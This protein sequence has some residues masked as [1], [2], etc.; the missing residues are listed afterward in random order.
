MRRRD[1]EARRTASG[2]AP[3]FSPRLCAFA[4]CLATALPA[5][6]QTAVTREGDWWV[7]SFTGSGTLPPGGRLR[8]Q[9]RGDVDA[10]G[11][12]EGQVS[13]V[14][15]ARVKADN[16]ADAR[17][18]LGAFGVKFFKGDSGPAALVLQPGWGNASLK[19][20]APRTLRELVVATGEGHVQASGLGGHVTLASNAGDLKA[21]RLEGSLTARSGGGSIVLGEIRGAVHAST[22]GGDISARIIRGDAVLETGGGEVAVQE[23]G[24]TVRASTLGGAVRIS[25]AGAG[26]IAST[27]GGQIDVGEARGLVE[28]RNSGG[29]LHVGAAQGVRCETAAGGIKLSNVSG[30]L[31]CST[32]IGS[33]VAR[34]IRGGQ[35]G[36]SFLSTGR[37][38]IT[39]FIPSNLGVKIHAENELAGASRRIVSDFPGISTRRQGAL[40]IAEG[41]VNGGGPLLRISGTGG[42]I[43]IKRQ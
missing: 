21:D 40:A 31:R 41:D 38:D 14:I 9:A 27:G 26:V 34:L 2:G 28:L 37:G 18:R 24:G 33:I 39:V 5:A 7:G 17:K 32:A 42:T 22:A 3:G 10:T 20:T 13:W 6:A 25:R 43:F 30:T 35:M 12:P 16:E 15:Q 29:G 1:T 11:G 8:V 23:V 4:L 19:L 36:E